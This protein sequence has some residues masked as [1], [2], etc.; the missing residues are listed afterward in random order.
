VLLIRWFLTVLTWDGLLPIVVIELPA[1]I[2]AIF[3]NQRVP[4]EISAVVLPITGV[5]VRI[6]MGRRH[7]ASN[8][9]GVVMRRV[10]FGFLCLGILALCLIE[11][12]LILSRIMPKNFV[13]MHKED[14]IMWTVLG[15][16]YLTCM[17]V[18][19]YPGRSRP[20]V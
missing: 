17:T 8:D 4:V 6:V 13:F 10:Q 15:C 3:P 5:F 2:Q 18:A 7:I 12:V 16:T 20:S 9:C 11:T 19:M 14:F 1:I